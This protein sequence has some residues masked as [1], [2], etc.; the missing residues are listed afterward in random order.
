V[1]SAAGQ[2]AATDLIP[3]MN[4]SATPV[5]VYGGFT[6]LFILHYFARLNYDYQNKYLF[7]A[8]V[9]YDGASN[10]GASSKWGF[11]PG[12]SVGWN[13][14]EEKFWKA[15]PKDLVRLKLRASYGVNGSINGLGD[16]QAQGTYSVGNRYSS[17]P[18]IINTVMPNSELRW[19][20][21]KTVDVGLDL[22]LF[23]SRINVL[24]DYYRK[25]TSDLI[26]TQELPP[27]TGFSGVST[28]LGSLEN[29]GIELELNA[30][31]LPTNSSFQWNVAF[32][33]SKT[34]HKILKL[35]PNGFPNNQIG[36]NWLWDGGK[37]AYTWQGG[38]QEGGRI[39]D[40]Y[41]WKVLGVYATDEEASHAPVDQMM[42]LAD[43]TKYAGDGIFL[44]ADGNGIIDDKDRVYMGTTD[45]TWTGGFTNI[46]TYKNFALTVRMDYTTGHIIY[47]YA[48]GFMDGNWGDGNF[49]Q[50]MIDRSWKKPGDIASLPLYVPSS[51]NNYT[52]WRGTAYHISGTSSTFFEKGDFLCLRELSLSY[53]VPRSLLQK[54]KL[55]N[56]RLNVTGSN[57]H[58][59]T[60]YKGMNPEMG[61]ND[62]GRYPMPKS[63]S[64][65]VSVSF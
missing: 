6:E 59:F 51:A 43:R 31:V 2:G 61:G 54:Y 15:L 8:N 32:N 10:L 30:R 23:K 19:E 47:N 56:I 24:F 37:N 45:P 5:S 28:N 44:D 14:H 1:L 63:I 57:L 58:Y 49:T 48:Q 36:G 17:T 12:V 11:F 16:Y 21:T 41:A 7:S 62:G 18:A 25:V 13:M 26:T 4:A 46:F 9:S 22:G 29:K 64:V 52:Y 20:Q 33:A 27:S 39:G 34:K 42:S 50:E 65:G 3:T 55:S 35:P 38:L 60:R 40:M 53:I